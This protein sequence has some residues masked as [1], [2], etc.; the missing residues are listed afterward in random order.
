M[1]TRKSITADISH[2]ASQ[3]VNE[4]G[5]RVQRLQAAHDALLAAVEFYA[6]GKCDDGSRARL[7]LEMAKRQDP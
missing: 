5:A 2:A 6:T 7:A 4:I 3:L 1:D